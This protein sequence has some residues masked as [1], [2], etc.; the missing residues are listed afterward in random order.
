MPAAD[1]LDTNVI[2]YA[3]STD[4]AKKSVALDLLA[5]SPTLS[6]QVLNE[7]VAVFRRKSLMEDAAIGVAI[8][9]LS[10]WCRVSRIG[11]DTIKLALQLTSRYRFSY[12]DA[13]IA[14][15]AL[16]AGCTVLYSEDMHHGQTIDGTLKIVNPF[17]PASTGP[18]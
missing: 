10:A 17:L 16:E 4:T 13:L 3:Y 11:I 5:E 12:Y 15:S 7:A 6:T 8:D 2:I 9:D 1:F 14:S 18:G